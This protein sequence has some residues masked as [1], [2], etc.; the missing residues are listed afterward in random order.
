M[1]DNRRKRP[2]FLLRSCFFYKA[3]GGLQACRRAVSLSWSYTL[4]SSSPAAEDLPR[5]SRWWII[6]FPRKD[7][8]LNIYDCFLSWNQRIGKLSFFHSFDAFVPFFLFLSCPFS[9]FTP[10]TFSKEWKMFFF[11]LWPNVIKPV[12]YFPAGFSVFSRYRGV[13]DAPDSFYGPSAASRP[14][15]VLVWTTITGQ[16]AGPL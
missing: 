12:F 1:Y 11:Y 3:H 2:L 16:Q 13:P 14:R 7:T 15:L 9:L 8:A 10:F 4:S 5:T 6:I